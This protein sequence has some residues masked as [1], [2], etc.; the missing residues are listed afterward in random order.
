MQV[1]SNEDALK[2]VAPKERQAAKELTERKHYVNEGTITG[3]RK[4]THLEAR[5]S[6]ASHGNKHW[7]LQLTYKG[8]NHTRMCIA[9]EQRDSFLN[10]SPLFMHGRGQDAHACDSFGCISSVA[11]CSEHVVSLMLQA[12]TQVPYVL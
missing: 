8:S 2:L 7:P 9:D 3:N 1:S 6:P 11:L 5:T 12:G 4:G 10:M